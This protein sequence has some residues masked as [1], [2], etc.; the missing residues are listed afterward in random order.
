MTA[1][2]PD[3]PPAIARRAVAWQ[4]ALQAGE[5]SEAELQAWLAEDE[6]HRQAW[7]RIQ[8]ADRRLQTLAEPGARAALLSPGN[9]RRKAIKTLAALLF[10]GAGG[11]LAWRQLPWRAA[12]ADIRTG[13]GERRSMRLANGAQ[14]DV[15]S[16][17]AVNIAERGG[18]LSLSLLRGEIL[19][20]T[21]GAG[22]AL[23]VLTENG[24]LR[25]VGTR[26]SVEQDK[27]HTRVA[28]YAGQVRLYPG[29]LSTPPGP[30]PSAT[31]LIETGQ[32]A[33]LRAGR[34]L[35]PRAVDENAIAW[36]DGMLVA[37]AMPLGQFLA[38]L[39]RHRP[40]HLGWDPAVAGLKVSG[41]YPLQ[42][43]D[44][45]LASIAETLPVKLQTMT[46]Y[47]VRVIP[48]G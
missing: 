8:A 6:Q 41:T 26:F 17:T 18:R 5:A 12:L 24:I 2:K 16:R 40:G 9:G 37:A 39:R 33:D 31:G 25:P 21:A 11:A 42:D 3:I 45:I 27:R 47:W 30:A 38:L 1:A 14:L 43:T 7:E 48:A 29:D 28:V 46:R 23:A 36:V 32:R 13:A 44:R 34:A 10:V 20:S 4:L 19:L 22:P 15:N 35:N